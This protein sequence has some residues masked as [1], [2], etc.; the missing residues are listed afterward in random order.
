VLSPT[1]AGA[2][3]I[4]TGRPTG[5][6]A[7]VAS[8]RPQVVGVQAQIVLGDQLHLR[9]LSRRPVEILDRSGK[10][11]I[12]IPAGGNH[13]WHDARVIGQ[14]EPPPPAPGAPESAPR[15]V[16]NWSVPGR[17][18]GQ[19]FQIDGFLGWVPPEETDEGGVSPFLFAGG[20]LAL[21][22]LSAVAAL[23]LGRRR[24]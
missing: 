4:G 3:E 17:A 23:L 22:G 2:H 12:R 10:P 21:V 11:F 16:K 7:T 6:V 8:I 14:G 20:A 15:F 19:N 24:T 5:F 13:A 1:A 18:A 9:N